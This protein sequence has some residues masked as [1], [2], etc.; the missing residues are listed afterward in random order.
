MCFHDLAKNFHGLISSLVSHRNSLNKSHD[1]ANEKSV[2]SSH[3]KCLNSLSL[4][5][6]SAPLVLYLALLST[7]ISPLALHLPSV[8]P[9][10]LCFTGSWRFWSIKLLKVSWKELNML[11]EWVMMPGNLTKVILPCFLHLKH[12][13]FRLK[14]ILLSSAYNAQ[15]SIGNKV[16]VCL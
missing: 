8:P 3:G 6:L 13:D 15:G 16:K 1:C 9:T 5:T 10:V 14:G 11:S 12:D 7:I 2:L 4:P